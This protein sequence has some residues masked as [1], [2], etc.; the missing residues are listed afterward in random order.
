M[1]GATCGWC[2]AAS[3]IAAC[4]TSSRPI[5]T[6]SRCTRTAPASAPSIS[7][8]PTHGAG[9]ALRPQQP[10]PDD[11]GHRR[12]SMRRQRGLHHRQPRR[13]PGASSSSRRALTPFGQPVPKPKRQYDAIELDAEQ[14]LLEQLV[15]ERELRLQPAVRQLLGH[16][17][18]RRN[19]HAD[20][21]RQLG[22]RAAAGRQHRASGR[23]RQ[24]RVGH[25]RD[26]LGF[27]RQPGRR[28]AGCRPIARTW[29]KLY[30][31]Y[32]VPFGTQI[33]GFF[34]AGSGTPLTTYVELGE[35]DRSCSSKAAATWAGR[36]C[37]TRTDLLRVARAQDGRQQAHPRSS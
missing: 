10:A 18:L 35:P 30:G 36:R 7:S 1:P 2:R 13:R 33:G 32:T 34:Y 14:A 25:R 27:A 26:L 37:C 16:R 15:L 29:S 9:R 11:R 12:A 19:P 3:A 6:S 23:Q 5:R 8:D 17:E 22:D 28:S 21:R 24:P 31:R 20:H 4:P